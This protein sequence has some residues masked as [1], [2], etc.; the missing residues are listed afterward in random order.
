MTVSSS[1]GIDYDIDDIVLQA[2][3]QAA[4]MALTEDYTHPLWESYSSFGRKRLD[5]II[6]EIPTSGGIALATEFYDLTLSEGTY[7]YDLPAYTLTVNGDGKFMDSTETDTTKASSETVVKQIG[8]DQW[9]ALSSKDGEGDPTLMYIHRATSPLQVWFWPIPDDA[10]STVRLPLHRVA[11][12]AATGSN[13]LELRGYWTQYLVYELA[14][15]IALANTMPAETY[16][17][18]GDK[19]RTLRKRAVAYSMDHTG[20]QIVVSHGRRC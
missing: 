14:F 4:V 10:N 12:S 8:R 3:Q 9:H 7:R 6:N 11:T 1:R 18:L 19:A 17:P 16:R 15:T 20:S 2:F 5:A 13:T